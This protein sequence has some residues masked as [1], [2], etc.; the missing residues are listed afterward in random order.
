MIADSPHVLSVTSLCI[1]ILVASN[2][3]AATVWFVNFTSLIFSPG[4]LGGL[5]VE[6]QNGGGSFSDARWSHRVEEMREPGGQL[7]PQNDFS[8]LMV[9]YGSIDL[10]PGVWVHPKGSQCIVAARKIWF[11][12]MASTITSPSILRVPALLGGILRLRGMERYLRKSYLFIALG[13]G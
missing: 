9:T 7:F 11:R 5:L 6:S 8:H 10:D 3:H 2:T 12:G 1:S 4:N 13:D